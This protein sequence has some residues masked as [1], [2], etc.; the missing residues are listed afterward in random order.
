MSD[1]R[2]IPYCE[3]GK[4]GEVICPVCRKPIGVP[5]DAML[6]P[7]IGNCQL[8]GKG[9]TFA[10]SQ[11]LANQANEILSKVVEGSWRKE[12]NRR[13][14]GM[15]DGAKPYEDDDEKGILIF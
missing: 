11:E 14:E 7:G 6:G 8:D 5:R 10:I 12:Y 3:I 1:P 9:H 13:F 4:K 15:P 2:K